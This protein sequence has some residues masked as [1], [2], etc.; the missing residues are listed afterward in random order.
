MIDGKAGLINGRNI[1]RRPF[2]IHLKDIEKHSSLCPFGTILLRQ[3]SLKD[4]DG[5]QNEHCDAAALLPVEGALHP[6]KRNA[7]KTSVR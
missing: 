3:G 1:L 5:A 4:K 6:F 2:A 7:Q